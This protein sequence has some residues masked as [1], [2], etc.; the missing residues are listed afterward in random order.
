MAH[1]IEKVNRIY[2][3]PNVGDCRK[4]FYGKARVKH[5]GEKKKMKYGEKYQK[6]HEVNVAGKTYTLTDTLTYRCVYWRG[7]HTDNA[8]EG[9]WHGDK[10]IIGCST[11]KAA[12][13]KIRRYVNNPPANAQ[14]PRHFWAEINND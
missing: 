12:K 14:L 11:E 6:T 5:E 4:S 3:L 1:N 13:A 9:L 7:W 10:Q 2:E 8:G